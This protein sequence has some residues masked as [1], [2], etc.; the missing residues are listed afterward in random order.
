MAVVAAVNL[1]GR[2]HADRFRRGDVDVPEQINITARTY[3]GCSGLAAGIR[4]RIVHTAA[5]SKLCIETSMAQLSIRPLPDQRLRHS[6]TGRQAGIID[7]FLIELVAWGL[8]RTAAQ[9]RIQNDGEI[10]RKLFGVESAA[11]I[12]RKQLFPVDG[13]SGS[14]IGRNNLICSSSGKSQQAARIKKQDRIRN[15]ILSA[16]ILSCGNHILPI[17]FCTRYTG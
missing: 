2:T 15:I 7:V 3:A 14:G 10:A 11:C 9:A 4:K 5:L 16:S 12:N 13:Q 1:I 17:G 6:P 8:V